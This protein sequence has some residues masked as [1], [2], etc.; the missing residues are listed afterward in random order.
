MASAMS[1]R[2]RGLALSLASPLLLLAALQLSGEVVASRS[3][4][5]QMP[6]R[7]AS[8]LTPTSRRVHRV[9]RLASPR[10]ATLDRPLQSDDPDMITQE[11]PLKVLIA[12]SGIG[13][14]LLAN[15]LAK[16]G[17][18]VHLFE[19]S[20]ELRASGGPILIQSNA[21]ASIEAINRTIA[22]E[23]MR[24][25][26]INACRVNGV[27]D[28]LNGKWF[29]MFDTREPARR[30]GMPLT[31]VIKR[32]TLVELFQAGTRSYGDKVQTHFGQQLVD[33]TQADGKVYA[34]FADG[35][36]VE[37]D[38]LV[39]ADGLWSAVRSV[40]HGDGPIQSDNLEDRIRNAKYSGYACYEARCEFRPDEAA[41][42][43]YKIFIGHKKYFVLCDIGNGM[44]EWYAF[45]YTRVGQGEAKELYGQTLRDA[46]AGWQQEVGDVLDATPTET[47][48]RRDTFDRAPEIFRGWTDE[49][50][51]IMGDAAHPMMPNLGQGGCQAIEDAYRLSIE[52]G[53]VQSRDEITSALIQ[54]QMRR[55]PRA[56]VVQGVARIASDML[57]IYTRY[58]D[59]FLD[60]FSD[61]F[62]FCS[63]MGSFFAPRM[64][65]FILGW[66]FAPD[67]DRQDRK[68]V[69]DR[70]RSPDYYEQD[71]R[72]ELADATALFGG[73]VPTFE[74]LSSMVR[75]TRPDAT[76]LRRKL[77][78]APRV[79]LEKVAAASALAAAANAAVTGAH[80][81]T[82][83]EEIL[84]GPHSLVH[85]ESEAT[86]V[87][88]SELYSTAAAEVVTTVVTAVAGAHVSLA[89]E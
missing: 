85:S 9:S 34:H 32:Q 27:K 79:A 78:A 5:V 88:L 45:I 7:M 89:D 81:V 30:S 42:V 33:Y 24:V 41:I 38:V 36:T 86:K 23:A 84:H 87:L 63:S 1:M 48:S 17:A 49:H 68:Y 64:F 67:L 58:A 59:N 3:T 70:M 40:L 75:D 56:A 12:G 37:G 80:G 83:P 14:M 44:Q 11:R 61:I 26:T 43:A 22:R 76:E 62:V 53:Q 20:T 28:G 55:L 21:L 13:G 74:E 19:K 60:W 29:C 66:L 25:G 47:I 10:M 77:L 57:R 52:L 16:A 39:G 50:V 18:E 65:P 51:A 54:Y 8:A 2:R 72:D 46:F 73:R 15:G 31:R 35:S 71:A 69:V 4:H 6:A 82:S